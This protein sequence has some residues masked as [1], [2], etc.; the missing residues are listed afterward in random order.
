VHHL[1]AYFIDLLPSGVQLHGNNHG[2]DL[3]ASIFFFKTFLRNTFLKQK[4]HSLRVGRL[5]FL[6]N[7][8]TETPLAT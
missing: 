1:F 7:P 8:L 6:L 5:F 2:L 3:S 4:T